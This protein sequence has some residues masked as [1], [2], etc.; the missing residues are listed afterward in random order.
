MDYLRR[1]DIVVNTC[2]IT[3]KKEVKG[4]HEITVLADKILEEIE[5]FKVY[6]GVIIP[7]GD[8]RFN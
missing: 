1:M 5:D 8:A 2:S 7:G 3:A 4:A 6:D